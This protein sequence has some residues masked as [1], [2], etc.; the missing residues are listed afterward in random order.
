VDRYYLKRQFHMN[1]YNCGAE[2]Y[3]SGG[4]SRRRIGTVFEEI[5]SEKCQFEAGTSVIGILKL[6]LSINVVFAIPD[7]HSTVS[8]R[9]RRVD[10]IGQLIGQPRKVRLIPVTCAWL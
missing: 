2:L 5:I 8:A 10:G 7:R 9:R 3:T 1:I 4:V 6:T